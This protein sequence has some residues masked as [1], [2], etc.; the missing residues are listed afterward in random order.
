MPIVTWEAWLQFAHA[1]VIWLEIHSSAADHS[2]QVRKSF[3]E[4]F[5]ELKSICL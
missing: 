2:L 3:N 5:I 4:Y 1:H